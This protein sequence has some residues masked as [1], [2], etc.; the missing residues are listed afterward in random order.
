MIH[1]KKHIF[2]LIPPTLTF[3]YDFVSGKGPPC[4]VKFGKELIG[5]LIGD[6]DALTHIN[7]KNGSFFSYAKYHYHTNNGHKHVVC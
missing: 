1:S 3:F 4:V 7:K 2:R 5:A 6:L